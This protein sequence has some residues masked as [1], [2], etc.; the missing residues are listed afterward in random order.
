MKPERERSREKI[1]AE[2]EI[3]RFKETK[4]SLHPLYLDPW[5]E[6]SVELCY[7]PDIYEIQQI[8]SVDR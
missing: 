7:E 6:K 4:K 8:D 5:E 1:K 2:Q 3:E